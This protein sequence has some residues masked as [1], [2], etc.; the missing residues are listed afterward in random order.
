MSQ[1]T[2]CDM[3]GC[4]ISDSRTKG[5]V[6]LYDNSKD[7]EEMHYF[8]KTEHFDLCHE[9]TEKLRKILNGEEE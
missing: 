9:C 1:V 4:I 8:Y 3:C 6:Q 5:N 7:T 2:Q